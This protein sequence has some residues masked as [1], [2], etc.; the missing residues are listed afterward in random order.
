MLIFGSERTG[1][2]HWGKTWTS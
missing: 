1:C 2:D